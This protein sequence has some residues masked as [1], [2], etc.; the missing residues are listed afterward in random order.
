MNIKFLKSLSN[1]L[2]L[3]YI[4]SLVLL[5]IFFYVVVHILRIQ[6]GTEIFFLLFFLLAI[7]G[8]FIIYNI[9]NALTYLTTKIKNIS[10]ET[11]GQRVEG[12]NREDELGD[13]ATAF[14]NLLNRLDEAFKREQQ[15]IADIAHELK[16]PLA[17]MR[18]SLEVT[19]SKDRSKDDY[20]T[21]IQDAIVE[22]N[23]L[24]STLKNVLDL[25]WSETPHEQ[26]NFVK[27]DLSNL[28]TELSD[29]TEKLASPH[30][31]TI[32][33]QIESNIHILGYKEKL[34]RALINIIENAVK[35]TPKNGSISLFLSK[36]D[37]QAIITIKDTGQ[38]ILENE[39]PHIFDRFYRGSATDKVFGSGIGLSIAQS[40][41]KLHH[42]DI[43]VKS[44]VDQETIF[45]V[46]IPIQLNS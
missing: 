27:M 29:I 9:T 40:I 33:S 16:T 30:Q 1:K 45:E 35:Y 43:Q 19:L 36:K 32:H 18:S 13:L 4:G 14:N 26:K 44:T 37:K 12:I 24:S 2:F 38:G 34:A 23:H 42:G 3:W 39:I 10:R 41:I 20:K 31:Q 6:Y 15:F 5:S 17:T 28:M 25:A 11:L 22:T 46:T 7:V 21:A 8:F